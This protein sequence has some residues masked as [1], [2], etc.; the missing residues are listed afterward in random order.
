M[1]VIDSDSPPGRRGRP[2]EA[3][4]TWYLGASEAERTESGKPGRRNPG[5]PAALPGEE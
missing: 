3:A 2:G 4:L 1:G 5:I